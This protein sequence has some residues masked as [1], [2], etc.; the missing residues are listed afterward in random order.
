LLLKPAY[1]EV[2]K[3]RSAALKQEAAIKGLRRAEKRPATGDRTEADLP[4]LNGTT[5]RALSGGVTT[6][7]GHSIPQG[8]KE[9]DEPIVP[10][11]QQ[12]S[13]AGKNP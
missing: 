7:G 13:A 5:F 4:P 8:K 10:K 3:S 9:L 1:S 2:Q 11:Q 12:A 6:K